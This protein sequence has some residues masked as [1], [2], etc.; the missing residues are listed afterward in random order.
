MADTG[1]F[2]T[3]AE[4][5]RKAG[6][7]ASSVSNVEAYINDFMT[8]VE[9]FINVTCKVNFSDTYS[10]LNADVKGLLKEVASDLAAMYVINYD[11]SGFT[12]RV[13][14]ETMLDVLRDRAMKG[15]ELLKDKA[16]TD[17]MS[18]A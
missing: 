7:N 9:S 12:N 15:L 1:I 2:A 13:E 11:L 10:S 6:A 4:V 3:T 18:G 16:K 17:F 14:A 8:Q 5:Q